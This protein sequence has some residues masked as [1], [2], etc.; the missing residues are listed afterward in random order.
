MGF[1]SWKTSDTKKSI[2]NQY[3]GRKTF[4]V[5]MITENGLVYTESDYEGYG[6]F[7]GKDIYTLIAEMNNLK[8]DKGDEDGARLVAIDLLFRTQI[9]NGERTYTAG[10]K[11][12]FSWETPMKEEGGKTPNQLVTEGWIQV[13]PN[14]YGD[15]EKAAKNGIKIPKLVQ[16]LPKK[17]NWKEA[18]DK[19]PYPESCDSQG[20]FY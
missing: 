4:T 2:A 17:E 10:G 18:W 16:K 3:S 14:G 20:Y 11:D 1:F 19:L 6:K 8:Y 12:F 7:G 9:T 15:W 13:Y 5:H